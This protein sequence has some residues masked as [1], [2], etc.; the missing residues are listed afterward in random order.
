[1]F[2][3]KQNRIGRGISGKT[4][5]KRTFVV[6]CYTHS[7][8]LAEQDII[9]TSHPQERIAIK[10]V[11]NQLFNH[12]SSNWVRSTPRQFVTTW[13][14]QCLHIVYFTSMINKFLW[15]AFFFR[16]PQFVVICLFKE[17]LL[18]IKPVILQLKRSKFI[19]SYLKNVCTKFGD[20][21]LNTF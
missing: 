11:F 8:W 7:L 1:M 16:A 2:R 6:G 13:H 9:M 21:S 14:I 4:R 3:N 5:D 15:N 18:H 17:S 10:I 12:I 19:D 20:R